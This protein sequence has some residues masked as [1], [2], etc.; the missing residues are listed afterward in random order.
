MNIPAL[1]NVFTAPWFSRVHGSFGPGNE[2]FV[3]HSMTMGGMGSL[4]VD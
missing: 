4:T 2:L 3:L 1:E